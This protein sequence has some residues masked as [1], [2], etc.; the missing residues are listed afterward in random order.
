MNHTERLEYRN[1]VRSFVNLSQFTNPFSV[2]L[3]LKQSVVSTEGVFQNHIR[4]DQDKAVQNFHH[5]MNLL[6]TEIYGHSFKRY[7]KR[8]QVV[9]FLEGGTNGTRLH[10][11][12]VIDCP[13]ESLDLTFPTLIRACWFK[14]SYGDTNKSMSNGTQTT[15][16]S[17]ISASFVE[18]LNMISQSTGS[19]SIS[20]DSFS[21]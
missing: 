18:R 10:Y 7:G 11:H 3:T 1:A 4:I 16:G 20:A 15:T 2:T 13:R 12:C 21:I 14:T 8:V 19:I 17:I 5:F 6:N 9:P